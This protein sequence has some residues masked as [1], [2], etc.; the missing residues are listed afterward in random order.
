MICEKCGGRIPS[1]PEEKLRVLDEFLRRQCE[2]WLAQAN[3]LD[4]QVLEFLTKEHG[5]E[6]DQRL[7]EFLKAEGAD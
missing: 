7:G 1:P 2:I 4:R 6:L 5:Q 3:E